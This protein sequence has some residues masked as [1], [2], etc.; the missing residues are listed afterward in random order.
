MS[1]DNS[2]I[3][4]NPFND[5]AGV[6]MEQGRVQTDSD[7]NEWLAEISRRTQAGTLDILGHAVYPPT[8]PFAFQ[9][10]ASSS[11][12]VNSIT[13]GRGRMYV[14]GLLVE[15][16]GDPADATWDPA[17]AEL[18]GS[19]QPPLP[20]DA[21]PLNYD[22]QPYNPGASVPQTPG[23]YLAYL[24]VWRRPV[25]YIEDP[26]LVDA[27]IGVDT[28]GRMQTAWQVNLLPLPGLTVNGSV[29]SG[30]FVAN[31]EVVQANTSASAN[32]IGTVAGSGSMTIGPITGTADA[33][34][35]WV[36]QTSGAVFTPTAAPMTSSSTI[37]GSV[38]SGIFDLNE[39]VV[40]ANTGASANLIGTVT[41][42]NPMIIGPFTGTPDAT[43]TWVGQ[44]SGAV[45]TPATAP[46]IT[47]WSCATP[48]SE[49]PWPTTSG[50]LTNGTISS[51][52]SGP[53]CLTTG[54][55]YT[56]AENQFYRV[57]IHAPGVGGGGHATFKWSRENAS[58]QTGV[59]DI[60][61]GTNSLGNPASILTVLSLGRDQ[62]LGFLPGN[63]IEI[64]NQTLDDNLLPGELYQIDS[65]DVSTTSI[66]LTTELSSNFQPSSL[67]ANSYTRIIRWDQ[68]GTVYKSDN[69]PWYDLDAT[70]A[71]VVNGSTGIP[72]PT[73]GSILI[74]EN[75][76]TVQFGLN[77]STGNYRCMNYWNFSARTA[78]DLI[79]PLVNAPPRGIYPHF[80]KLSIV[81]FGSSTGATDCRTP[82]GGSNTC[83]DCGCCT[84][85]VGD[86]VE[87]FGK[88]TS[89]Q[90]AINSLPTSGGEVCILPGHYYE[91]V[92]LQKLSNVVIHGCQWQTH[93][94]SP[95]LQP[96]ATA[97]AAA[98]NL[99]GGMGIASSPTES[100]L[101]AVFTIVGCKHIEL[102]SFSI[103]AADQEVGILL[104]R[105]PDTTKRLQTNAGGASS[106]VI[107]LVKG[108]GDTDVTIEDL[109]LTASTLPAIVAISVTGLKITGSQ[110]AMQDVASSYAA[111]YLCGDD[112]YFTHNR[113]ELRPAT[114]ASNPVSTIET[115]AVPVAAATALDEVAT[116][117]GGIHV[118]G[119]S[120]RVFIVENDIHGGS[121][122]GITLGNFIILD[123]DG[124]DNGTLTGVV[125]QQE[126][127]CSTGGSSQIPGTT[128]GS[129]PSPIAAG[130]I[131]RNLHIDRN[132]IHHMGMC[133]IG[134]VG[135]FDLTKTLEVISLVNVSITAN[136]ISHTLLRSVQ[137]SVQNFD[138]QGSIF[139][140]GAIGLPDIENLMIRDNIITDFGVTPGAEVCG[141]FVQHGEMVE[142]S[143]NQIKE[144]RDWTSSTGGSASSTGL[145][146]GILMLLVTPPVL[147]DSGTG[148]AW[149]TAL[150]GQNIDWTTESTTGIV[151]DSPIYEPGLPALRIQENVVRVALGLALAAVGYGPFEI[152]GNHFTS[153][154]T[155]TVSS[156][157]Q[158]TL[159]VAAS[160]DFNASAYTGALTIE[161]FNLGLALEDVNPGY[162]Y[163]RA[164]AA[165][166]TN[167][168]E[169]AGLA[170]F[171]NGGV[172][173]TN[174]VCLLEAWA[175][176]VQ[177]FA[178]VA[179]FSLDHVLFAN[180]QLW[181]DGP[182]LTALLDAF[183]FGVT[184]QVCG[185]RLQESPRYPVLFSGLTAGW[186]NVTSLNVSTYCLKAVAAQ[187]AWLVDAQNIVLQPA[188]CGKRQTQTK[189]GAATA[190]TKKQVKS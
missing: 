175:S 60:G 74:L 162:G 155:V 187:A 1:F 55:G 84:C 5:Y 137:N 140:Y 10:N 138:N 77:P 89:I 81:T 184:I 135:F 178:S 2:R 38:T 63:W 30:T 171:S 18:S 182:T 67:T 9:I 21:N 183:L 13:I 159:G 126:G 51:G 188:L 47:T 69:S 36:G 34:D 179:I 119:P 115:Q 127:P 173:F 131:I 66:T 108:K 113:V 7:W 78:N 76:I 170:E 94:Y 43:D 121:H 107:L 54:T 79:D 95:A 181:L 158:R 85:T 141:V 19:P 185:N 136:V 101:T 72:V 11:G 45:Y 134:P 40:Q 111:A 174:N 177:G 151:P 128:S 64:T 129:N 165:T 92:L 117:P 152:V 157:L 176:G 96:G 147:E 143:R 132:R 109:Y 28:T 32:L 160:A 163:A 24:E 25:T 31:E 46:V 167:V 91:H 15:N 56:G 156:G 71:G 50:E 44:T 48:D 99:S 58:V 186:V 106:N 35:L 133:G 98:I 168:N 39:E 82:W 172:L 100:A 61:P 112:I 103:H 62:V 88:Y 57:E 104:D 37:T 110:I 123:Q 149:N 12:G 164:F 16:H 105:G 59:T 153:G 169:Q 154:G 17:L 52:P 41:G 86:G 146:A 27:A 102:R 42:S 148:S 166:S 75:G 90:A 68:S 116:A 190:T 122:N 145:R 73:D 49:I 80:T 65:V 139:G 144:T 3:T 33:T 120:N 189:A 26:T 150:S 8:T 114:A 53:C 93:I 180:N 29:T 142:I 23:Q 70:T 124:N 161:I 6:V 87:S 97:P 118:A 22:S 125:Y 130:G 83:D 4:F 20:A 14:D